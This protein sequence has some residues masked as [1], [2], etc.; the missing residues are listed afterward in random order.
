MILYAIDL[1]QYFFNCLIDFSGFLFTISNLLTL[2]ILALIILLLYVGAYLIS[3]DQIMIDSMI[4]ISKN[5]HLIIY[6]C[7]PKIHF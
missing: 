6:F 7:G 2:F 1:L 4:L 5:H 3:S